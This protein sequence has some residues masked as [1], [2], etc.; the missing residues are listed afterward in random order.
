MN[1]LESIVRKAGMLPIFRVMDGLFMDYFM[2]LVKNE[3]SFVC[4]SIM[5]II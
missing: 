3:K 5:N 2:N 4:N 1:Q